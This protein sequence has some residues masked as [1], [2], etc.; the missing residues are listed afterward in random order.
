MHAPRVHWPGQGQVLARPH[1][2]GISCI[3]IRLR[4]CRLLISVSQ[5]CLSVFVSADTLTH[6]LSPQAYVTGKPSPAAEPAAAA[7]PA[8]AAKPAAAAAAQPA[9]AAKPA[10]LPKGKTVK[11]GS[12]AGLSWGC[13]DPVGFGE[14]PIACL[15]FCLSA[16]VSVCFV[17]F[18]LSVYVCAS[19]HLYVCV[20]YFLDLCVEPPDLVLHILTLI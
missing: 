11:A 1:P 5:I 18:A 19:T 6:N 20:F 7:K 3:Y 12:L 17:C 4:V 9:A 14:L 2:T 8:T 16:F 15:Y 13:F 10:P